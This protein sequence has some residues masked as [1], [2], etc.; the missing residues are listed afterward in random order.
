[1]N[2]NKKIITISIVVIL[3]V[4]G[5]IL[6]FSKYKESK[7][8]KMVDKG[9]EYL[10]QKEYE[11][12]ITTLDLV[13]DE[14]P[15][16][17]EALKL[18]NMVDKYLEAKKSFDNGDVEK[19]NKLI[20]E[21]GKE[22]SNYKGFESDVNNLKDQINAYMEKNKEI[23]ENINKVRSLINENKY[24]DAEDIINKLEKDKL[25]DIQ[26]KQ[27]SDLKERVNSELDKQKVEK[28]VK[29]EKEVTQAKN[30]NKSDGKICDTSSS[31]LRSEE[32]GRAVKIARAYAS[33]IGM[34]NVSARGVTE[35][36][37]VGK[38]G[39]AYMVT[40]PGEIVVYV[41]DYGTVYELVP[42]ATVAKKQS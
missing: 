16:D 37:G 38:D 21:I 9:I 3:I 6:G 34:Q 26:K 28:K 15:N 29:K 33:K 19:A 23:D 7:I 17:D 1:M 24:N 14:K 39:W 5:G 18:K 12:A 20:D 13:L 36:P 30:E 25:N 4:A 35:I 2:K 27:V 22:D 41:D 32:S 10:N 31:L 40:E 42:G 11:K 8:Q